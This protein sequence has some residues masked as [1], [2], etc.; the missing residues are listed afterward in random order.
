[1]FE[2]YPISFHTNKKYNKEV[3]ILC[4]IIFILLF[5]LIYF[6]YIFYRGY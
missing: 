3:R 4:Y 5:I 6:W 2:L 1:M